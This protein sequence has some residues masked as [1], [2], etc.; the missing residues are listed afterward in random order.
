MVATPLGAVLTHELGKII[1]QNSHE[2]AHPYGPDLASAN[3]LPR[4][5]VPAV[6]DV[7]EILDAVQALFK[8]GTIQGVY[9]FAVAVVPVE[10]DLPEDKPRAPV[11]PNLS[12]G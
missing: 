12:M 3:Q 6:K 10:H 11:I 9:P 5:R 4:L 1:R 2:T 7:G 8:V